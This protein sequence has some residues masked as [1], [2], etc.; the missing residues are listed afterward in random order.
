MLQVHKSSDIVLLQGS[1]S[2]VAACQ[3]PRLLQTAVK[4]RILLDDIGHLINLSSSFWRTIIKTC[5]PLSLY[6]QM[7]EGKGTSS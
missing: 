4:D 6:P 3:P 2:A 5:T 1:N 7:L